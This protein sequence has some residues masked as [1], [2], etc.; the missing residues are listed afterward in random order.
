MFMAR[1]H[2]GRAGLLTVFLSLT[3]LT[4]AGCGTSSSTS[5]TTTS[6]PASTTT[7]PATT[8]QPTTSTTTPTV[9]VSVY[10]TKDTHL[11]PVLRQ[12][13]YTVAVATAAMREL[14]GGPSPR[15]AALGLAS[16]VPAGTT[17]LGLSIAAG[18]ATVNLSSAFESGGGSTSMMLRLA[19]VT[20]TL[21]QF[22]T[23]ERV[24][25][26]IDGNAVTVFG[27]EGIVLD[28]PATRAAFYNSALAPIFVDKPPAFSVVSSPLAVSGLANVFEGQFKIQLLN[29][30]GKVVYDGSATGMMGEWGPWS[31]SIPYSPLSTG[32]LTLRVFD[33]S[34]KDGSVI[35]L[36]EVPLSNG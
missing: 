8:S 32:T 11:Y 5:P 26:K 10:F 9:G 24:T 6:S 22:P 12:P 31:I 29:S 23:V 30:A 15:E 14:L 25:F 7:T 27:G 20:Y 4:A 34:A 33:L 3:A 35:D 28:H 13:R 17:L 2:H 1:K 19:Q 36:I 21:T 18:T 16:A